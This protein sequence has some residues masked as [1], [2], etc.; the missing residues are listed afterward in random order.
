[1][2]L[3]LVG[4]HLPHEHIAL[5]VLGSDLPFQLLALL[6]D[7]TVRL[8]RFPQH[9]ALRLGLG[10]SIDCLLDLIV[11]D[12]LFRRGALKG[13]VMPHILLL[14]QVNH[15]VVGNRLGDGSLLDRNEPLIRRH[16]FNE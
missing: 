1:M 12:T 14:L 4:R 6:K 3:S 13:H 5:L 7:S 10:E 9:L 15:L 16:L 2:K 11:R 8:G